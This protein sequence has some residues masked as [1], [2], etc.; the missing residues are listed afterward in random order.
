LSAHGIFIA[1]EFLSRNGVIMTIIELLI[2]SVALAMDTFA[3]GICF[4]LSM[5]KIILRKAIIIGLYFGI[6]QAV[7]P[8]LG[9]L[10]ASLFSEYIIAYDHWVAFLLLCFIGGKMIFGSFKNDEPS[11]DEASIKPKIMLPLAIATSIDALAVGVSFSFLQVN[12]LP[13]VLIIG[14]I[15]FIL[16]IIGVKIGNIFGA[17]YKSKAEFAGGVILILIGTKILLEHLEILVL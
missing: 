17:K 16:S 8:L 10:A 11:N 6:F 5:Q 12:I 1:D 4:G 14:A 13:A 3:V 7:M 9:F 2:L 15:T